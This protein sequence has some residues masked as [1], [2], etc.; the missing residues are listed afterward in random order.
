MNK[1]VNLWLECYE[2]LCKKGEGGLYMFTA[3]AMYVGYRKTEE[4]KKNKHSHRNIVELYKKYSALKHIVKTQGMQQVMKEHIIKDK[5]ICN[6]EA[7]I[8]GT[9]LTV[10]NVVNM[11]LEMEDI[12]EV[13]KNFP[14]ITSEEQVLAALVYY[15]KHTSLIRLIFK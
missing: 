10:N 2:I 7:T 9:R 13:M 1:I 3:D 5:R 15:I 12:T 6:G 4:E 11:A 8:K 14:S